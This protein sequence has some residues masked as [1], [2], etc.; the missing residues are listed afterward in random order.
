MKEKRLQHDEAFASALDDFS[1]LTAMLESLAPG[2]APSSPDQVAAFHAR[3][4]AGLLLAAAEYLDGPYPA[5]TKKRVR[6]LVAART[7]APRRWRVAR[8]RMFLL[9]LIDMMSRSTSALEWRSEM[10]QAAF[11]SLYPEKASELRLETV[12]ETIAAW[13]GSSA[14]KRKWDAASDL[15]ASA[16][17]GVVPARSLAALWRRSTRPTRNI[18]VRGE[19]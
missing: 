4:C 9:R 14:K 12:K 16:G 19:R 6:E 2:K 3:H 18:R 11:G 8:A 5:R 10:L 17:L 1:G 15:C 7:M 13:R